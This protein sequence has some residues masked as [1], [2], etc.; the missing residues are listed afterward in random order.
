MKFILIVILAAGGGSGMNMWKQ[1]GIALQE[2][3]DEESCVKAAGTVAELVKRSRL[4]YAT[5][6][7]A[8]VPAGSV[9]PA[10]K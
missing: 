3:A 7:A 4:E 2:F 5:V 1:P 6:N 10:P 8:C 9:A